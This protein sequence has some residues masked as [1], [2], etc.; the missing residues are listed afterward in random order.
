M[1]DLKRLIL[2]PALL[3]LLAGSAAAQSVS[4]L[5]GMA[6]TSPSFSDGGVIADMY[7]QANATPISPALSWENAPAGTNSF[8]LILHDPDVA[9]AKSA[10]DNLHWLVFNLPATARALPE[11]VPSTERLPDG[12]IQALNVGKTVGYRGPGA[13]AP[14]PYHHYT[15]E[16]YALDGK[17]ALGPDA[18]RADVLKAMD[19]HVLGKA[20]TVA[21]FH[22]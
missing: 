4:P 2:G 12:A 18:T 21:R 1:H 6:L 16:L 5:S 15:F 8:V 14:G 22:R 10:T 13:R 3:L 7:T 17:L 9:V 11:G 19:G 20:V